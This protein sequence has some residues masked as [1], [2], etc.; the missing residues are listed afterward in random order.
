MPDGA[1]VA[2]GDVVGVAVGVGTAESLADGEALALGFGVG[3]P[4]D[5]AVQPVRTTAIAIAAPSQ[6]MRNGMVV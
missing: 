6:A 4:A 1:A 3:L 2:L 5:A